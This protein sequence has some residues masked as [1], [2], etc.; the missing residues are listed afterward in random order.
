LTKRFFF[1]LKRMEFTPT[2]HADSTET[3]TAARFSVIPAPSDTN[4]KHLESLQGS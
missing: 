3:L 4:E 2:S 1:P